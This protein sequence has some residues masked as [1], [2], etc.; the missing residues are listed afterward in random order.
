MRA[1]Y[2]EPSLSERSLSKN[3]SIREIELE[4]RQCVRCKGGKQCGHIQQLKILQKEEKN[5]FALSELKK[6]QAKKHPRKK[7]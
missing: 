1:T 7:L 2:P 5:L 4:I 3:P 6:S